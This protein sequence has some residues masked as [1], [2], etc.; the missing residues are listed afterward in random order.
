MCYNSEGWSQPQSPPH[1]L[2]IS[3]GLYCLCTTIQL[4]SVPNAAAHISAQV[5]LLTAF[6]SQL[7][8]HKS[9]FQCLLRNLT[10][11]FII[12]LHPEQYQ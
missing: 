4:L 7:S 6:L 12:F 11:S 10:H 2:G 9:L 1:P 5:L 8:E 3:G